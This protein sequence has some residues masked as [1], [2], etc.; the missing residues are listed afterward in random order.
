[1]YMNFCGY[2]FS[3]HATL[4]LVKNIETVVIGEQNVI[5]GPLLTLFLTF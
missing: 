2:K 3:L 1:M 5:S 4:K